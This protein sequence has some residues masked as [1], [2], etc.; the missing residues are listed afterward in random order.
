M[1]KLFII[2]GLCLTLTLSGQ[3]LPG[4]V[5]SQ[6][7]VSST[8]FC[9]E[10][11]AV[12][13]EF[14]DPPTATIAGYQNTMVASLVDGGYWARM[15]LFYVMANKAEAD[16]LLMW[17]DP[18]AGTFDLVETGAGDLT[19]TT[20][21]GFT[22]DGTNYL[23]TNYNASTEAT[24]FTLNSGSGL[25]YVRDDQQTASVFG[26]TA[27]VNPYI[28]LT[29][30]YTDNTLYAKINEGTGLTAANSDSR[31]FYIISR[32]ASDAMEVYKNGSSIVSGNPAVDAIPNA[33]I[34]L[35]TR[36]SSGTKVT[37]QISIFA[38]MNGVDDTDATAINTIIE[39]Y[40]DALGKG[41]EP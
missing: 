3:L 27:A 18:D 5:A 2:L 25:I 38:I 35:L 34:L 17:L 40:M 37:H 28:H 16:A 22:G 20:Y 33:N 32:T 1:R 39:T 31:G 9:A 30:R 12:Y 19:F 24:N 29:V 26:S 23:T 41:V 7:V 14:S 6:G 21:E 13:D 36:I 10:Y 8:S 4:V 11:Q 15:D